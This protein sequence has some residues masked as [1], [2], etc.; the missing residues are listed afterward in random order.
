MKKIS[1]LILVIIFSVF[2]SRAQSSTAP[3]LTEAEKKEFAFRI[4]QKIEEFQ[5]HLGILSSADSN[6]ETERIAL[7]QCLALFIGKG[8]PYKSYDAYGNEE[9]HRP[10]TIQITSKY[11][12]TRTQSVKQYLTTLSN[13]LNKRYTEVKITQSQAVR[14]DNLHEVGDGRYECVAYFFQRFE[15]YRDNRLV[16]TDITQKKVRVYL[17]QVEGPVGLTWAIALGDITAVQTK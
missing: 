2:V 15:G 13:N 3:K 14:V 11:R 7:K 12:A 8:E 6:R 1:L 17:D 9:E 10:V 5:S 4:Q 16:Y